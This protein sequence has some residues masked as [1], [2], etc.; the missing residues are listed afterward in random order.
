MP[1]V[2][3]VQDGFRAACKVCLISSQ[4]QYDM[5]SKN[6]LCCTLKP[7]LYSSILHRVPLPLPALPYA[8]ETSHHIVRNYHPM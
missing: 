7:I 1:G 2:D 3:A 5:L 6:G 8:G 4:V